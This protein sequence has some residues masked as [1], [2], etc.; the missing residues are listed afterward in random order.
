M[1][2]ILSA[3]LQTSQQQ[4]WNK[5]VQVLVLP[6]VYY[7]NQTIQKQQKNTSECSVRTYTYLIYVDAKTST[8]QV[9]CNLSALKHNS[10]FP[11]F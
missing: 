6:K 1:Y 11:K 9:P 4:V 7:Q 8:F 2:I 5:Y 3:H 10:A